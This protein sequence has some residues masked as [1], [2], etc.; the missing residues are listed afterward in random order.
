MAFLVETVEQASSKR[1]VLDSPNPRLLA[2][3]LAACSHKP[4]L[5]A[6]S[7]EAAKIE[8]LL[9]LAAEHE[10]DLVILLMDERSFTP[11]T[12]EEKLALALEIFEHTQAA[13]LDLDRLIFDPVL[14]NL[15]WDDAELR[16]REVVKTVRLL[17]SGAVF[18]APVR[19]M[20]G[21]SNLRSGMRSRVPFSVEGRY[22]AVLAGAGLDFVL[23]DV[24]RQEFAEAYSAVNGMV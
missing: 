17:S 11:P 13:G 10:T 18:Q 2:L 14:P 6:L 12:V 23:A 4:I 21:L 16:L 3:G 22:L 7:L 9:P 19:T 24:L 20:A 1:P 8:E 15:S 5:N